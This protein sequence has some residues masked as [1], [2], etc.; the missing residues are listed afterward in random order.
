MLGLGEAYGEA[1][2]DAKLEIYFAALRDLPLEHLRY[3]A[4]LHVKTQKFFPR[5][6]ELREAIEG[7]V[8][9]RADVAWTRL[10]QMVR[11]CGYWWKTD[12]QGPL[13]WP[14]DVTQRTAL[15]LYG[16]WR[17]LCERLPGDGPE[18]L[19][20]AKLFKATYA[21]YARQD[22]RITAAALENPETVRARLSDLRKALEARGLPAP[23]LPQ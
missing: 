23:G 22:S 19:G 1:V 10:L 8:S 15:D 11:R 6:S 2:S 5:V 9:D 20:A 7:D 3:V 17:G 18:L 4:T 21:A 14:D 12:R 13:P 16:N